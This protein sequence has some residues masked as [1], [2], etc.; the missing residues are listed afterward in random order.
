MKAVHS[1]ILVAFL[2]GCGF[3]SEYAL[4]PA[5]CHSKQVGGVMATQ[6]NTICWQGDRIVGFGSTAGTSVAELGAGSAI[7]GATLGASGIIAAQA[8]SRIAV[9]VVP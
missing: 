3:D 7:V 6:L 9:K 4:G 1:F 2:A 8:R 5:T